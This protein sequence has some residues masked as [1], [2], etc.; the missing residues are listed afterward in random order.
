MLFGCVYI[1]II[2]FTH[3]QIQLTSHRHQQ[4]GNELFSVFYK[5]EK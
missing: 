1:Y 4:L 3:F 2:L 5:S